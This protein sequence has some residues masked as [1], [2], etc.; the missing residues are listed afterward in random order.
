MDVSM[1]L[2]SLAKCPLLKSSNVINSTKG[3]LFII[4]LTKGK[5]QKL[6]SCENLVDKD[7]VICVN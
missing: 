6:Y 4:A 2:T 7:A 1:G 5:L 3:I